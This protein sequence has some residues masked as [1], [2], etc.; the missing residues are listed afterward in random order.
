MTVKTQQAKHLP[1]SSCPSCGHSSGKVRRYSDDVEFRGL[2]LCLEGLEE[3]VCPKCKQTWQTVIQQSAYRQALREAYA[4]RREELRAEQG[5]LS[6]SEI[7]MIRESLNITQRQ[8][9][10]LFGG[11]QNAFNKYES[12]EVLQSSAMDLLL[13]LSFTLG[14]GVVQTLEHARRI[15]PEIWQSQ[16]VA[17]LGSGQTRI[18]ALDTGSTG[19]TDAVSHGDIQAANCLVESVGV[20]SSQTVSGTAKPAHAVVLP[21]RGKGSKGRKTEHMLW[22][23]TPRAA[24]NTN[25]IRVLN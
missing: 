8:A 25:D 12:G 16:G 23:S 19:G 1:N 20:S 21:Y 13:R 7:R 5:L 6:G 9:S 15:R 17:M 24:A 18:I 11:G 22:R 3:T 10:A 4:K 14:D 2:V